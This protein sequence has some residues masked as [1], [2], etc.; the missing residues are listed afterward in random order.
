VRDCVEGFTDVQT[1]HILSSPLVHYLVTPSWKATRLVRQNLLL[2]KPRWLS[3]ITFLS[4][5]CLR[6][7]SRRICSMTFP[8]TEVR[9]AGQS[10][11]LFL[12]MGTM[13]PF[14]HSPGT[15][16][17]SHDLSNIMESGLGTASASSLR[18]PGC[19]SSGPTDLCM[20]RFLRWF[21]ENYI[22]ACTKRD[23]AIY[24]WSFRPFKLLLDF[25]ILLNLGC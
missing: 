4:S 11:L 23:T 8:G 25:K 6:I 21:G 7:A 19:I 24:F 16:P 22:C 13:F 20:F 9:L 1:D 18:T 3:R 15:S 14:S 5:M 2:V 10:F 17:D 12:K